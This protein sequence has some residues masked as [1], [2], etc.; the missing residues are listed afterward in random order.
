M[1]SWKGPPFQR[2]PTENGPVSM[3]DRCLHANCSVRPGPGAN[4]GPNCCMG[5]QACVNLSNHLPDAYRLGCMV[6]IYAY[7]VLCCAMLVE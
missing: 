4:R 6:S 3:H 2:A 7:N 5:G 1:T